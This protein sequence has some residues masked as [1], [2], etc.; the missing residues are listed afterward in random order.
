[1]NLI[2]YELR[3][4][5]FNRT[6]VIFLVCL[7]IMNMLTIYIQE[8]INFGFDADIS[9]IRKIDYKLMSM[10]ELQ[11]IT[12]LNEHIIIHNIAYM[13][14]QSSVDSLEKQYPDYNIKELLSRYNQ[15]NY[16]S[17][18]GIIYKDLSIFRHKLLEVESVYSYD[19]Y[20][21]SINN[22]A[23]QLNQSPLFSD[24]PFT[25]RNATKTADDY[26][27]LNVSD[28]RFNSSSGVICA[29]GNSITPILLCVSSIFIC[30]LIFARDRDN[31]NIE[32]LKTMKRGR[33]FL[34]S[35]KMISMI[36]LV[37]V[38]VIVTVLS[39]YIISLFMYGFGDIFM[40]IQ[41]V[42]GFKS[43]I[44][45]ISVGQ[46]LI[47]YILL[48]VLAMTFIAS[49]I[50]L[51]F[52]SVHSSIIGISIFFGFMGIS[53]V[54]NR[55]ISAISFFNVFKHIN[56]YYFLNTNKIVSDYLNI[57]LLNYPV[58]L[59]PL[60][61]ITVLL[62]TASVFYIC[63]NIFDKK[64][65]KVYSKAGIFN[66]KKKKIMP[67]AGI[68]KYEAYKSLIINPALI[69]ILIFFIFQIV[70]VKPLEPIQI[71]TKKEFIY[72]KYMNVLEGPISSSKS[73]FLEENLL[74]VRK[75]QRE[76]VYD[77]YTDQ[78]EVIVSIIANDKRLHNIYE[79]A[80]DLNIKQ[81]ISFIYEKGYKEFFTDGITTR[82]TV[83]YLSILIV[84]CMSDI[85]AN[86]IKNNT[87]EVIT[88]T[89]Y[90]RKRTFWYK[91]VITLI[92]SFSVLG[93]VYIP[94][95]H[96]FMKESGFSCLNAPMA[97]I[98]DF[99][100]I[101]LNISI[102]EYFICL[103][104]SKFVGMLMIATFINLISHMTGE[105]V[106][107]ASISL[108]IFVVPAFL[109]FSGVNILSDLFMNVFLYGNKLISYDD[110]SLMQGLIITIVCILV[111]IVL[112]FK[113]NKEKFGFHINKSTY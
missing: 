37:S 7:V 73:E 92:I 76:D 40:P 94:Y 63:I 59:Y 3:K 81:N 36:C 88:Y 31:N 101:P 112:Y 104:L 14:Q 28:I 95:I 83:L 66:F 9:S 67:L 20:I 22:R 71:L 10:D 64:K 109:S 106:V 45:G 75:I 49:I 33:K 29:T 4:T 15:G 99:A 98:T 72:M 11:A 111:F 68:F 51:I 46:Y 44:F 26:N 27:N 53:F 85:F 70:M 108:F 69:I 89:V 38:S 48:T 21:K 6:T 8:R 80:D 2:S 39:S 62:G 96:K 34:M 103:F 13:N 5:F 41:S 97:C 77:S 82:L 86:E 113:F 19:E 50:M 61:Y 105:P 110:A 16:D 17:Y 23:S 56:I 1:M 74:D 12:Y 93:A 35:S 60:F 32:L 18:T 58:S 30:I 55:Q 102:L 47:L 79:S 84:L 42:Y 57:N 43:S 24:T 87:Y 54:L 78:I 91:Q 107:T 52:V 65:V 25:I 100:N 90:G